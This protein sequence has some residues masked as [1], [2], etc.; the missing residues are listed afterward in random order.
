MTAR[1]ATSRTFT[2]VKL[3]E[4]SETY[5]R[6]VVVSAVAS[7]NPDDCE[8]NPQ[9]GADRNDRLGSLEGAI[10]SKS[11]EHNLPDEAR[12]RKENEGAV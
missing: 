10:M 11:Q 9:T 8:L 7:L 12:V 2:C 1:A 6:G 3:M 4:N 5:V